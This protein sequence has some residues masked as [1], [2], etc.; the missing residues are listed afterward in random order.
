MN[1]IATLV[2]ASLAMTTI[3]GPS[4]CEADRPKQSLSIA[5]EEIATLGG[6]YPEHM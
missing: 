5:T 3:A 1:G 6:V 2:R 4:L